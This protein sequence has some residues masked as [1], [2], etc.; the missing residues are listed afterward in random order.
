M[1]KLIFLFSTIAL[2]GCKNEIEKKI[3][4]GNSVKE[5]KQEP[6]KPLPKCS[7]TIVIDRKKVEGI[8][9][10]IS[11]NMKH[12][13]E[14]DETSP[15]IFIDFTTFEDDHDNVKKAAWLK[16]NQKYINYKKSETAIHDDHVLTDD[17]NIG[18]QY[19]PEYS[20][21][22]IKSKLYK[23][24]S[25]YALDN[26][27]YMQLSLDKNSRISIKKSAFNPKG[28]SYSVPLLKILEKKYKGEDTKLTFY[29]YKY[30]VES[31]IIFKVEGQFYNFSHFPFTA[32]S[33][34]RASPF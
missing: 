32:N 7:E 29:E 33:P 17:S 3:E 25:A 2:L 18:K 27:D 22:E 20:I 13:C 26:Y 16:K 5:A 14:Y 24:V 30:G 1:K 9:N 31:Y 10:W 12:F 4:N 34:I 11:Y 28:N 19:M 21:K 6:D 23:K 15:E 8:S